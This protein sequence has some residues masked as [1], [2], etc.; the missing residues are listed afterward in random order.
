LLVERSNLVLVGAPIG[1]LLRRNPRPHRQ[2]YR[3]QQSAYQPHPHIS[4]KPR[5]AA[6]AGYGRNREEVSTRNLKAGYSHTTLV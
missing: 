1:L 2:S 4:P 3:E 6:N 5:I